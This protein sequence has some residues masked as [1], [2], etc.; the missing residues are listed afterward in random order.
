VTGKFGANWASGQLAGPEPEKPPGK[1]ETGKPVKVLKHNAPQIPDLKPMLMR[2]CGGQDLSVLPTLTDYTV[3]Q[4]IS[5]TGTDLSRWPTAKHFVAW[6]GLAPGSRQSGKRKKAAHVGMGRA[7]RLFCVVARALGRSKYLALTG[8][9]RR[10]RA[11]RGGQV[12][13]VACARKVAI[14]F[15]LT[16]TKGLKYVEEGLAKYEQRFREQHLR[17]LEKSAQKMGFKLVAA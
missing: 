16:M 15:Y 5:E 8:F 3:L 9:Y 17:R 6:L 1:S 7:G 11:I 12:A 13:V 4:I 14:L 2:A 10:L